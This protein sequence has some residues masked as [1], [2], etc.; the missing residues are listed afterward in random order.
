MNTLPDAQF[1][2]RLADAADVESL[3]TH[4]GEKRLMALVKALCPSRPPDLEID[5]A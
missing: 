3:L 1:L 4:P 5:L 2:H